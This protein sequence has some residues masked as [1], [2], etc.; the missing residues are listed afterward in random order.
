MCPTTEVASVVI[1]PPQEKHV[2][3]RLKRSLLFTV[4]TTV[5]NVT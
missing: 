1:L 2:F 5:T 4:I 3:E